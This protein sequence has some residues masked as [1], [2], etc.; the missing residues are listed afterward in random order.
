MVIYIFA[1]LFSFCDR[2]SE[3]IPLRSYN[4]TQF[5]AVALFVMTRATKSHVKHVNKIMFVFK[6]RLNKYLM[7]PG[8]IT[9]IVRRTNFL[10]VEL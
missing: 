4:D 7:P 5:V 10:R 2:Y 8:Q 1:F 9:A 3:W 6:F